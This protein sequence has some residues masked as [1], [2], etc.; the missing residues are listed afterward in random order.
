VIGCAL[1][2]TDAAFLQAALETV[3][4]WVEAHWTDG[5]V[6]DQRVELI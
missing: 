4:Q 6:L 1:I 3:R 5:D 2:G